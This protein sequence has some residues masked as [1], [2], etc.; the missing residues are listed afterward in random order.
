MKIERYV[1]GPVGTNCYIVSNEK[2]KEAVLVDPADEPTFF[3]ERIAA[4]GLTPKAILLTHG[5]FD[6]ILAVNALA[7]RYGVP[8]FAH[9]E[10]AGVLASAEYTLCEKHGLA[11]PAV[12]PDRLLKDGEQFTVAGFDVR[13]LHTPGHTKGGCCYYF[14]KEKA[15]FTGDTLFC[16][17]IGRTDFPTGDEATLVRSVHEKLMPLPDDVAV[18]PGHDAFT[19]IREERMYNPYI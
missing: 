3:E 16:R 18:Y 6:H 10:E 13:A 11:L 14:E 7:K 8:V 4:D 19:T 15:V 1:L 5:H 17:S 9:E 12:K 2:T